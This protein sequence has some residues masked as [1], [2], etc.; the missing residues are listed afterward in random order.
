[1][2]KIIPVVLAGGSGSRLW[3]VSRSLYPKQFVDLFDDGN[4]LFQK[5]LLRRA[6]LNI[7]EPWIVVGNEAHRFLLAQQMLEVEEASDSI[8]LEPV[9]RDSAPA[10]GLAALRAL[11]LAHDPYLLVQTAD[12]L[13]ANP[14]GF[15]ESF[16]LALQHLEDFFL[17]GIEPMRPETGYGY[18]K[19]SAPDSDGILRVLEF[20]EKP[21]KSDA[22]LFLES[23]NFL[24]NSGMFLLN[25]KAYLDALEKFESEVAIGTRDAWD[26]KES[27]GN[28][29]RV[30]R[31]AFETVPAKSIDY[32]VM[33]NLEDLNAVKL[34]A[35]WADLGAWNSVTDQL[36]SDQR[37]NSVLGDAVL[38]DCR[39][40][41]VRSD[42]RLVS[43]LGI[44]EI[45]IIDTP[46]ALLVAKTDR[47][48]DVKMVV[49]KIEQ[50][51]RIEARNHKKVA[52]PWGYY[53][54]LV[55]ADG[56]Q[57]KEL[58]V[59]PGASLSLQLHHHRAEH[60]VVVEG[61]A[62]VEISGIQ[63]IL[64]INES[65]YIPIG[66]KHRLTNPGKVPLKLIEVQSGR[67]LGEDDIVRF[68]DLYGRA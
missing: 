54:T 5:T 10:V 16:N 61:S 31:M 47:L 53:Q 7:Q 26:K 30:D 68:D 42:G 3:P 55:L 45:H 4:S 51:N 13:I 8:I 19:V 12:H 9:R 66:E 60:W 23:G 38:V 59:I 64:G 32:A 43:A 50:A 41:S 44:D 15:L 40:V 25:A 62:L 34:S 48:Q 14:H 6:A 2:N 27:D 65:T 28:F 57:V 63:S 21:K 1:M 20:V 36:P 37:G 58:E 56:Y 49:S 29:I 33:E 22:E 35:N 24:W 39:N 52:R 18:L 11:D 17:F 67:Y 46:D